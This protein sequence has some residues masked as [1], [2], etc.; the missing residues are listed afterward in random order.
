[1]GIGLALSK[2]IVEAHNGILE[3]ESKIGKGARFIIT[4]LK[5]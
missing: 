3:A 2:S 1:V 5:Y 4:F